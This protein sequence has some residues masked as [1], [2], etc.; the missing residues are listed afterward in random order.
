MDSSMSR[1]QLQSSSLLSHRHCPLRWVRARVRM[2]AAIRTEADAR[3]P[4]PICV[5]G[6][7][8]KSSNTPSDSTTRQEK[9]KG[10]HA[11]FV[12][13]LDGI[14]DVLG[15][16]REHTVLQAGRAQ[17]TFE[18]RHVLRTHTTYKEGEWGDRKARRGKV[19]TNQ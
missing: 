5:C 10:D 9:R 1:L 8:G 6:E 2:L 14:L 19:N 3:Y 18:F 17:E 7:S 11:R 16:K 15:S 4:H 13:R 12:E